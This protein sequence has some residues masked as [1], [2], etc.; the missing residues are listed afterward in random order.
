MAHRVVMSSISMAL[1]QTPAYAVRPQI[2]G[3]SDVGRLSVYIQLS[4]VLIAP[5][6]G[7]MARLS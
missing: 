2:W 7:G 3:Y 4:P 5:T 6:H 1:S